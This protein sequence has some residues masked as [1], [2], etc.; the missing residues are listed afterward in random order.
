MV[1]RP[2]D[3]GLC[4]GPACG[5]PSGAFLL[6]IDVRASAGPVRVC[7]HLPE[8]LLRLHAATAAATTGCMRRARG[9]GSGEVANATMRRGRQPGKLSH[10]RHAARSLKAC[11]P[12]SRMRAR[13]SEPTVSGP[14]VGRVL[15]QRGSCQ[16]RLSA[17]PPSAAGSLFPRR[18]PALVACQRVPRHP[19]EYGATIGHSV[20]G[21]ASLVR[22]SAGGSADWRT[23]GLAD[24]LTDA[25]ISAPRD[26]VC[27][28]TAGFACCGAGRPGLCFSPPPAPASS[29]LPPRGHVDRQ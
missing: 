21:D 1:L 8:L 24:L 2:A 18:K 12:F 4:V 29:S 10:D 16:C 19:H 22:R 13:K 27:C 5:V 25:R 26:L 3:R 14:P 23:G 17:L 9:S 28:R 15:Q 20:P 11:G 7:A 6:G